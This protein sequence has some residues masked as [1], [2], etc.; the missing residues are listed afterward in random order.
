[1]VPR[2][3]LECPPGCLI[4]WYEIVTRKRVIF[5]CH[6]PK[7]YLVLRAV[8]SRLVTEG[9]E[10]HWTCRDKDV[11]AELIRAKFGRVNILT[12]TGTGLVGL[13]KELVSYDW[14]LWALTKRLEPAVL[15]GNSVS[16]AH[17]GKLA[18]IPSIVL[19]DDDAKANKQYPWLAYPFCTTILMP[20]CLKENYGAKQISYP[21]Y[22]EMAY[23]HPD[24]FT[25]SDDIWGLLD[26][27]PETPYFILRFISLQASHDIN[28]RGLSLAQK[29]ELL[30][31][32]KLC[33]R[34][35]VSFE[36]EIDPTFV[37][38]ILRIPPERMHDAL[39]F[40]QIYLGDSQTMAAEAAILGTPALRCNTFVGRISY[41]EELEHRY[42]LTYG[43][44]PD[45][46]DRLVA[47]LRQ[48]L[49]LQNRKSEWECRRERMLLDKINPT[50]LYYKTISRFL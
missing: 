28:E 9:V 40:A 1:M 41:L 25:P 23:L 2:I 48:I 30:T 4:R 11:L 37:R 46:F 24:L 21:S 49:A 45:H 16:V 36:G 17:V 32:L 42:K 8:A 6:H 34:V 13:A 38:Y 29:K 19:N 33:G 43:F 35:F 18:G 7:H 44:L 26:I 50:E 22:H 47:K 3:G 27:P 15:V 31:I 20:D 14:R 39:A 5:D 12:A 10:V